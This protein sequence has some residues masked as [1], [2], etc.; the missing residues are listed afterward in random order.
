MNM[1]TKTPKTTTF[2]ATYAGG[3]E[4]KGKQFRWAF[5]R[6]GR[7]KPPAWVLRDH[8]GYERI[9]EP[10]WRDSVP[11]INRVLTNYGMEADIS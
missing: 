5:Y 11:V 1:T 7:L 2:L 3:G 8:S 9:L 4:D 10:T 6:E